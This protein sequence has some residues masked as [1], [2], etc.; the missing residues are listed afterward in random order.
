MPAPSANTQA[1]LLLTSPLLREDGKGSG[2]DPLLSA[3]EYAQLAARLRQERQQ[4]ADLL[5]A[6]RDSLLNT[7]S[8]TFAAERLNQLLSR[9]FQLS[10]AVEHWANR[11]ISVIGRADASY[12]RQFKQRLKREAPPLLYTCGNLELLKDPALAVVGS[13]ETPEA[14]LQQAEAVGALAA[15]AEVVIVSGAARGVDE[16]AMVGSLA[17]GGCAIG[18]VADS[19]ERES[20]RPLWRQA[21]LEGRLLLHTSAPPQPPRTG[22]ARQGAQPADIRPGRCRPGGERRQGGGRHLGGRHGAAAGPAVL[23]APWAQG[24]PRRPR[25]GGLGGARCPPLAP[26]RLRRGPSSPA[27]GHG[28]PSAIASSPTRADATRLLAGDVATRT[29]TTGHRGQLHARAGRPIRIASEGAGVPITAA[30]QPE[31]RASNPS[32]KPNPNPNRNPSQRLGRL[33]RQP[34]AELSGGTPQ[35]R[36]V[37]NQPRCL[38]IRGEALVRAVGGAGPGTQARQAAARRGA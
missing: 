2:N 21:L 18:V 33:C 12:P 17:A 27:G 9:G 16:A 7:L 36:N 5:Q 1:V 24:S 8:S 37:G 15:T 22:G 29:S 31:G 20:A 13:R 19:L 4:P 38:Q 26:P 32:P 28:T 11:S 14:L 23:P 35:P 25:P 3:A 34:A 30:P 10:Q 6:P